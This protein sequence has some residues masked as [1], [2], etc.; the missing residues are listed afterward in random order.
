[1][2]DPTE[3]E[4]NVCGLMPPEPMERVLEALADLLPGQR[5]RMLIDREPRPLYRILERN[6][7]LYDATLRDD[8]LYEI[9]IRPA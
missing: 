5:I 6:N 2:P 4:L 3:I 9:L 8:G 7:Y 1:M